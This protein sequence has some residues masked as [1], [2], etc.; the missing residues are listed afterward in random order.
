[1]DRKT[2]EKYIGKHVILDEGHNGQYICTLEKMITMP[3]RPWRAILR[4][5]GVLTY[6]EINP[7]DL[8]LNQPLFKNREVYECSGQRIKEYHDKFHMSYEQSVNIAL[9]K[10]WE[11][12]RQIN[13]DTDIILAQIHQEMR[14][15]RC[16]H[17][18]FE[19]RYVYYKIV[20]KGRDIQ[21]Y[22]E[23]KR[24][25][26]PIEGC[27]FEFEVKINDNWEE[28]LY[29]S[30]LTFEL[31][32]GK[33]IE[34]EHGTTVRLNKLQF[35][36]YRILLNELEEPA[37]MAL[38]R[39]LRK[40]GI[41]HENLV[42]CHN[43]LLIQLLSAGKNDSFTGVN[44]ISYANTTNQFVVQHHYERTIDENGEDVTYDRFE[45]TS[46]KGERIL[47]AYATHISNDQ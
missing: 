47:T 38:E 39:G 25:A 24:E 26:L 40:L 4:I 27:P 20:K 6:P 2:A 17:L 29:V 33:F 5:E 19:D 41:D 22:D 34:L 42:Y 15:R 35:D 21:I 16:E 36:P 44:F 3:N 11:N 28:A 23:V 9:K 43:S 14:K 18:L 10:M 46:D 37:L 31:N 8:T 32:N 13:H 45:F 1:M 7:D 12:F 30:D